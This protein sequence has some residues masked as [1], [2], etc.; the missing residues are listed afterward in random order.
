MVEHVTMVMD[1]VAFASSFGRSLPWLGT[2]NQSSSQVINEFIG[3][4]QQKSE[5][6]VGSMLETAT[7][8][9][10]TTVTRF[11]L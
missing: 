8:E 1:L 10:L 2:S 5:N 9:G 3:L 7:I 11:F 6:W 4:Q